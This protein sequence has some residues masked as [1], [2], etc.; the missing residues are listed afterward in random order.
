[1]R[2][3]IVCV[4]CATPLLGRAESLAEFCNRQLPPAQVLVRTSF[5][6]PSISFEMGAAQIEQMARTGQPEVH[7]G[8]TQVETHME[9]RVSFATLSSAGGQRLCGRPRIEVTLALDRARV[10]VA[11]E[12]VGNECAVSVVWHHELRHFAIVQESLAT[13]ASE[14]ERMMRAYYD[15]AVFLGSEAETQ[16][17]IEREFRGR[18]TLEFET[19]QARGNLAHEALDAQDAQ[20]ESTLCD[21]ALAHLAARLSRQTKP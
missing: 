15:G 7:F 18:W 11:R 4:L 9:P 12:L 16:E 3:L 5:A 14:L 2:V 1:M 20:A 19:L 17:R 8:L 10:N 6:E 21:G 13:T